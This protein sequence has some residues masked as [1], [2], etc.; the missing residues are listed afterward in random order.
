MIANRA[1]YARS[2]TQTGLIRRFSP[3]A[4][5]EFH[6]IRV[7]TVMYDGAGDTAEC[8][9]SAGYTRVR[10]TCVRMMQCGGVSPLAGLTHS[11]VRA[12]LSQCISAVLTRI[13]KINGRRRG[14]RIEVR[15]DSREG[16]GRERWRKMSIVEI[17]RMASCGASD[18]PI[19]HD[20]SSCRINSKIAIVRELY[21][22]IFF[23]LVFC[24][25][26]ILF[27][28][29]QLLRIYRRHKLR[30]PFIWSSKADNGNLSGA[31]Y[32]CPAD[33]TAGAGS[34]MISDF[35]QLQ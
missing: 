30:A 31:L 12:F 5:N 13:G 3:R 32:A 17:T 6:V 16:R 20:V 7:I 23:F 25:C 18:H 33:L 22:Y 8:V 28:T 35:A 10:M 4:T 26:R 9:N 1:F 21:I 2:L 29:I 34:E 15:D 19:R 14:P 24:N 27:A 11:G